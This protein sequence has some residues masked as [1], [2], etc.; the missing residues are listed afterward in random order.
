MRNSAGGTHLSLCRRLPGGAGYE[1]A[2]SD[3]LQERRGDTRYLR[4]VPGTRARAQS[5]DRRGPVAHPL[6]SGRR[7]MVQRADTA[8]QHGLRVLEVSVF[9]SYMDVGTLLF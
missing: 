2:L 3:T 5:Q 4:A 7:A 1:Q 8:G 9:A 6:Q